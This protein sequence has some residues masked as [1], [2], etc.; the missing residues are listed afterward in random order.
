MFC[1]ECRA[2]NMRVRNGDGFIC[3]ECGQW[4]PGSEDEDNDSEPVEESHWPI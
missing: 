1:E 2:E 3:Y 4:N